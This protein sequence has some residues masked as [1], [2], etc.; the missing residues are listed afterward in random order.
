MSD[1]S[2]VVEIETIGAE[3]HI[4][5]LG[6]FTFNLRQDFRTVFAYLPEQRYVLDL[7]QT[8]FLDSSAVGLMLML[9]DHATENGKGVVIKNASKKLLDILGMVGF[10]KY[11]EFI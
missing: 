2:T 1:G 3:V 6:Q 10:D 7:S 8:E 11:F 5:V 9:R 4:R